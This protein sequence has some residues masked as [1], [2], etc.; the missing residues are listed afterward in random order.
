[1]TRKEL[2]I[3][4]ANCPEV[5]SQKAASAILNHL[6]STIGKQL[7]AGNSVTISSTFGIFKPVTRSGK[8]PGTG[9]PYTTKTVKFSPSAALKR[10]LN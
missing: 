2:L 5:K 8:A 3:E 7:A 6:E 10:V 1:M 4:L 9:N